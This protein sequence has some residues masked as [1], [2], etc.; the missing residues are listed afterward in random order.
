MEAHI[1]NRWSSEYWGR[2]LIQLAGIMISRPRTATTCFVLVVGIVDYLTSCGLSLSVFY[3]LAIGIAAWF[4]GRGFAVALAVLSVVVWLMAQYAAGARYDNLI[5]VI[6]NA[7]ILLV[8]YLVVVWLLRNMRTLHD[9]LETRVRQRTAALN[10][11]AAERD[12]LEKEVL[13]ISE[14]ERQR[15]GHDLH[16]SLGQHLTAAALAGQ[17]LQE[18]LT[19]ALSAEAHNA[20]ILVQLL[21]QAIEDTRQLSRGLAPIE[22]AG[23]GLMDSLRELTTSTEARSKIR[24]DFSYE[25][26]VLINDSA[27]ATHLYRIAQEAVNNAVKHAKPSH[28]G[29]QLSDDNGGL[30]L[31]VED[32]GIGIPQP[33]LKNRGM[34][35]WIMNHR[36]G[37]IGA[38]LAVQHPAEG[39]TA[40][41]CT[42][43]GRS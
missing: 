22:M 10:E 15:I 41:T 42:L 9:E 40:I 8:S 31:I 36:A 26:P 23:E 5:V 12:R 25:K 4:A 30:E 27:T 24:C 34:G 19:A 1:S 28:I 38:T 14:R 29:I 21:N 17:V 43:R 18:K 33:R 20:G 2:P 35:L 13:N 32:N 37:M 3:L 11:E 7:V 16:D 39:G 6:W